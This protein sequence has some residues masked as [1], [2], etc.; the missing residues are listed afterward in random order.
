MSIDVHILNL[1]RCFKISSNIH[2][3]IIVQIVPH[4]QVATLD[5]WLN[6]TLIVL[7][8]R[9]WTAPVYVVNE[10]ISSGLFFAFNFIA[11]Y[12]LISPRIL[13]LSMILYPL[14]PTRPIST[15][16]ALCV[17][18]VIYLWGGGM[19]GSLH[20]DSSGEPHLITLLS[21][22][23]LPSCNYAIYLIT[24]LPMVIDSI[25]V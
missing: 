24:L 19:K 7:S 16:A 3:L 10:R 1:M 14:I 21:H 5:K 2:Q 22:H 15:V 23:L 11:D 25:Q 12:Q 4:R 18:S 17:E 6:A 20:G 8:S 9:L 13:P